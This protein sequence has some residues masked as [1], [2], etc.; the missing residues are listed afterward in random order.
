MKN[1]LIISIFLAGPVM[2]YGQSKDMNEIST[3]G[4]SIESDNMGISWT[5]GE[6]IVDI[7]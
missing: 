2:L 5:I 6:D 7:Y 4:S 1:L 3:T